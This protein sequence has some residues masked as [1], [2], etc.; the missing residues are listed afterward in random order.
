[1]NKITCLVSESYSKLNK[2]VFTLIRKPWFILLAILIFSFTVRI[3]Y[4]GQIKE[5]IFDEF[6]FVNFAKNYINHVSFFDIHPPLGKLIIASAIKLFGDLPF[7][8]RITE[9]IFGTAFIYLIYLTGK[10]LVNRTVGIIAAFIIAF[11][12]MFLVYS[13]VGLMD[14]FLVFFIILTFYAILKFA[15]TQKTSFLI[16]AGISLGLASSVKYIGFLSYGM[17]LWVLIVKNIPIKVNFWKI[18]IF[19]FILP[20]VIYFLVFLANFPIKSL[21]IDVYNWQK[22]S[23][24]SNMNPE[25][26]HHPYASK[27]WGWLFLYRPVCFYFKV[28]S[29]GRYMAI[30]A[31]GNPFIWWTALLAL[32]FWI[33]KIFKGHKASLLILI[34]FLVFLIPWAFVK[35]SLFIYHSIPS[36]VF[37]VLG[38]AIILEG[39]LKIKNGKWILG[40]YVLLMIAFFCYFLPL[41]LAIPIQ[42]DQFYHRILFKNWL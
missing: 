32:P 19:L 8:W 35:R 1:M 2:N 21:L 10:E 7:V 16:L 4:L 5:L 37:L 25:V 26:L 15:K 12:G 31:L 11:D 17:I 33:W 14:I 28:L 23:L 9:V 20:L 30:Y 27:W 39:L 38:L 22:T 42:P 24:L 41:W 40:L 3:W 13:R 34:P 36:F 18:L 6:Y 29:D